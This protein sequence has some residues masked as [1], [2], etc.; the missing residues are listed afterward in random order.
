MK[1]PLTMVTCY[2]SSFARICADIE[3]L[4]F[5][6]VGDSA[7]MVIAGDSTTT[8]VSLEQMLYHTRSVA[9]GRLLGK[10]SKISVIGDLPIGTYQNASQALETARAFASAG[11]D[12]I[13]LEG[14]VFEQVSHLSQNNFRV[15]A[16]IG[17]TPQS[18]V[19]PKVQGKSESEA[20]RLKEEAL[21]L[22]HA[23]AQM[24]VLELV[25]SKLAQEI[26]KSL[27]IPTIGIGA[28][29]A[30]SGQVLVLYDLLG[31]NPDF[32]PKFLKKYLNGYQMVGEALRHYV[33]DV[34][35]GS[36]PTSENSFS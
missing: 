1:R 13:K 35:S 26:T 5:L 11:A 4:D 29:A 27:S 15:C 6:L 16:H 7:G 34:E 28:G 22:E 20:A 24:I 12:W 33:K 9:R 23:G 32:N 21:R 31:L 36:F 17:F 8:H 18:I 14:G 30:C 10:N 3:G 19:N 2:D 25:P